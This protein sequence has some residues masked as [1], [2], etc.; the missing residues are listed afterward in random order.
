MY[1][2]YKPTY[3][4]KFQ[5]LPEVWIGIG[6]TIGLV[7]IIMLV[8]MWRIFKKAEKKGWYALIPIYNLIVL[9]QIVNMSSWQVILYFIPFANFYPLIMVPLNLAKVFHKSSKFGWGLVLLP[10]VYYP[11]LAFNKQAYIGINKDAVFSTS[12][13]PN[14]VS[15]LTENSEPEKTEEQE[16]KPQYPKPN[17]TVGLGSNQVAFSVPKEHGKPPEMKTQDLLKSSEPPLA[18]FK[19]Q[20]VAENA[21]NPTVFM[22][23]PSV[24]ETVEPKKQEIP[25]FV[26]SFAQLT[27]TETI[28]VAASPNPVSEPAPPTPQEPKIELPNIPMP[29]SAPVPVSSIPVAEPESTPP[30]EPKMELPKFPTPE[31]EDEYV[32]CTHCGAVLKKGAPRCF[33]CGTPLQK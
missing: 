21:P 25:S 31:N 9:F 23:T 29:E 12:V 24:S 3:V 5:L 4:S 14:Q 30:Q 17:I 11:I 1:D 22:Q 7:S 28:S 2:D 6:I 26:D 15:A 10:I 8:S 32:T 20:S 18:Q 19:V 33:L 16:E 27:P 13:D